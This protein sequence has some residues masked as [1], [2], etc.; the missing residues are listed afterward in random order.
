MQTRSAMTTPGISPGGVQHVVAS[1]CVQP[2]ADAHGTL[3]GFGICIHLGG[4]ISCA[5]VAGGGGDGGNVTGAQGSSGLQGSA[6][7]GAG[8]GGSGGNVTGSQGSSGLQGSAAV[9]NRRPPIS[10]GGAA[11]L[12]GLFGIGI[13]LGA[14]AEPTYPLRTGRV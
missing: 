2:D 8:G 11:V 3:A 7:G 4:Q 1:T 6:A 13:G 14:G 5:Q 9:A 12:Q 10:S